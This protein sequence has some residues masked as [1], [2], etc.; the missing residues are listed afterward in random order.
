MQPRI[1]PELYTLIRCVAVIHA[2][3]MS[4]CPNRVRMGLRVGRANATE[5]WWRILL[6]TWR[7]WWFA[8]DPPV[9]P[10]TL[11]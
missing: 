1:T 2:V 3:R 11:I 6:L 7:K 4:G 8:F 10:K 5:R 9:D